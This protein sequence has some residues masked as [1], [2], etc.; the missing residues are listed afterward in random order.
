[1]VTEYILT[2][3]PSGDD[4]YPYE[5]II[6]QIQSI[7]TR[8][9]KPATSITPPGQGFRDNILMGMSGQ[10]MNIT[11]NHR[12]HNG[13]YSSDES[14]DKANGTYSSTVVTVDEQITYL[15]DVIHESS[16]NAEWTLTGGR[17]SGL[18]VYLENI[19]VPVEERTSP[20]W[21]SCRIELITGEAI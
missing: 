11:I 17:F 15:Q 18:P 13:N 9:E 20:R 10:T 21:R 12:I 14:V 4:P 6:S 1:M 3:N 16:F 19:D 7:D 8:E 5:Y 2:L